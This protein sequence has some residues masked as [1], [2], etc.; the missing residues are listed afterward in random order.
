MAFLRVNVHFIWVTILALRILYLA[1]GSRLLRKAGISSY[2][3]VCLNG[4]IRYGILRIL[5]LRTALG[6]IWRGQVSGIPII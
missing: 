1:K 6:L 4:N 5:R 2:T 3:E